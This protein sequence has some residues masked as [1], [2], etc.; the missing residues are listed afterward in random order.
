MI[1][2]LKILS[3]IVFASYFKREDEKL[4]LFSTQIIM[5][6][7]F[8]MCFVILFILCSYF[9]DINV[10]LKLLYIG[11][12]N[13]TGGIIVILLF[14][15]NKYLF[16]TNSKILEYKEDFEFNY[17]LTKKMIYLGWIF[18]I[19]MFIITIAL[20]TWFGSLK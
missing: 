13:V 17:H 20:A 2:S 16:F 6:L 14:L 18:L 19:T 3:I 8:F 5:T 11:K 1:K 15:L 4:A 10:T 9:L 12:K 7:L